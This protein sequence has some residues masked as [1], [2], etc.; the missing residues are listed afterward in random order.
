[1]IID[2]M[3]DKLDMIFS[4]Q[5]ELS[6]EMDLSKYPGTTEKKIIVL[7]TAIMHEAIE[8]QRTTN[9]KWWKK[10]VEFN[11]I[12]AV[13]ELVDIWHFVVQASIELNLNPEDILREYRKKNYINRDRQKN[14]Y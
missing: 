2:L 3:K 4:L 11:K 5:K 13:E 7:C 9:W 6:I 8:L 14:N 1:M 10:P 12:E